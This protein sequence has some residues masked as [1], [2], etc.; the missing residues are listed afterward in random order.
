M[1]AAI[2][3]ALIGG[4]VSVVTL[5]TN[6]KTQ[7]KIATIQADEKDNKEEIDNLRKQLKENKEKSEKELRRVLGEIKDLREKVRVLRKEKEVH[8]DMLGRY[9][10]ELTIKD[11][12]IK[13]SK[14]RITELEAKEKELRAR[15]SQIENKDKLK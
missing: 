5:L 3:I 13:K 2:I 14:Q 4:G 8:L 1:D 6:S 7:L 10:K 9:E 12:Y 11:N 15:I